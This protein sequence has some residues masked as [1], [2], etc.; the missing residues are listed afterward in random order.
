[1]ENKFGEYGEPFVDNKKVEEI[2]T[3]K[4]T[5]GDKGWDG[6]HS[7]QQTTDGGFIITGNTKSF[8]AG[9]LDLWL[10]KTDSEGRVK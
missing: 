3:W 7:V 10:I 4:H 1:M 9:W 5:F 8:G 2:K 6:G